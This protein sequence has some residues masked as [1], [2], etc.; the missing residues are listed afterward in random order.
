MLSSKHL[1]DSGRG[2]QSDSRPAEVDLTADPD[3]DR[4]PEVV[5]ISDDELDSVVNGK[6]RPASLSFP[7]LMLKYYKGHVPVERQVIGA[8][9]VWESVHSL[10][11]LQLRKATKF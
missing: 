4:G 3:D 8:I 2:T 5:T 7:P 9:S 11:I 6:V 1:Q 10:F